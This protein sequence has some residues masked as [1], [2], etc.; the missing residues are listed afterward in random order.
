M[1]N[2]VFGL[3]LHNPIAIL[4]GNSL[5]VTVNARA[6]AC[7]LSCGDWPSQLLAG[8]WRTLTCS[9]RPQVAWK[10]GM[11]Q[12]RFDHVLQT[13][14]RQKGHAD[15]DSDEQEF[16]APFEARSQSFREHK[17][18]VWRHLAQVAQQVIL[19]KAKLRHE[20]YPV[21]RPSKFHFSA[22]ERQLPTRSHFLQIQEGCFTLYIRWSSGN[23]FSRFLSLCTEWLVAHADMSKHVT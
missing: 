10:R 9:A 12:L 13:S 23:S 15:E 7:L 3:E 21:Q 19:S 1:E 18:A 17:T 16:S 8:L 14:F 4:M 6:R 5:V 2:G 20:K 22:F 11:T